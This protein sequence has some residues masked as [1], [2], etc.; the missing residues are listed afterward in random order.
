MP[1]LLVDILIGIAA[2]L[3]LGA[4]VFAGYLRVRALIRAGKDAGKRVGVV[5]AE[6]DAL[7]T[8]GASRR[9]P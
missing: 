7:Q 6:I 1:W 8:Q 2:L 5:T 9:T 3:V 4:V